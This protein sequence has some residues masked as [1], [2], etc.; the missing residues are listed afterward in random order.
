MSALLSA[1]SWPLPLTASCASA[2]VLS[3]IAPAP[4]T[5]ARRTFFLSGVLLLLFT[6]ASPLRVLGTEYVLTAEAVSH[7]IVSML[8]PLLL[9]AGAPALP[10]KPGSRGAPFAPFAGWISGMALISFWYLPAV[11]NRVLASPSLWAAM[12]VSLVLG[13]LA[14][15]WPLFEPRRT[16]RIKP[17]PAGIWYLFSAMIWL[18]FVGMLVAFTKPEAY[19]RYLEPPDTLGVLASLRGDFGLSRASDQETGGML[20]W[21]GSMAVMLNAVMLLFY[22]WYTAL[23]KDAE[24]AAKTRS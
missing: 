7:V 10:E 20:F 16:H 3:F 23:R 4:R 17:L 1:W 6:L 21:I 15:W 5:P 22:R 9:L 8:V 13:G 18:S 12:Q 2:L 19:Q 11:Y 24:A 14:F